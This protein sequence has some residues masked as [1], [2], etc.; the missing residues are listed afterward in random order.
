MKKKCFLISGVSGV[1]KTSIAYEIVKRD[2]RI[3]KVITSTTRNIRSNEKDGIDYSF[4]TKEEFEEMV[5]RG[6]F[7][8]HVEVY[9]NLYGSEKKE[10]DRIFNSGH[11]PLFV[12]DVQGIINLSKNIENLVKIFIVPDSID[13][14]RK[15]IEDRDGYSSDDTEKRLSYVKEEMKMADICDYEVVNEQGQLEKAVNEVLNII[16]KELTN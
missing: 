6:D 16:N 4:Y 7:F 8:E 1:G 11:I 12:C 2:A 5:N 13:N 3:E 14:L 9:G 15:R 10:V